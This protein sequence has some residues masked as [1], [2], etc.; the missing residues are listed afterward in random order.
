[1]NAELLLSS[2]ET[3]QLAQHEAIIE[4]GLKTFVDV[5]AA[6]LAIRDARLY[7][8]QYGTFEDYCR[9]RWGWERR[10]AYRLMDAAQAVENVS[11]WTQTIPVT[12]SQARPLTALLPE[13]QPIAWQ[14]AVETAPNGKV[15][16][17]HVQAVVT[18][19]TRPVIEPTEP[20]I[21]I[22][23]GEQEIIEMARNI[24]TQ[25][26]EEQREIVRAQLEDIATKEAKAISDFRVFEICQLP[27]E[28]LIDVR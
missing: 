17:A 27:S 16:A 23:R 10:H 13:T 14:R 21:I 2:G 22:A 4:R 25:R 20:E 3:A 26:R 12:E 18:D 28:F 8:A 6:L 9:E 15:T 24:R 5:G 19:M 11:N 1:M 7:R